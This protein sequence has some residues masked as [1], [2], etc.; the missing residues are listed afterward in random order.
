VFA[1][2][3][4]RFAIWAERPPEF[5]EEA[6]L[7]ADGTIVPRDAE[8]KRGMDFAYDGQ[9]SYHSLLISL[10]NTAEHLFCSIAV[11]IAR[12]R[13][14]PISSWTKPSSEVRRHDPVLPG[15]PD[16]RCD[17]SDDLARC[18]RQGLRIAV[19]R[20]ASGAL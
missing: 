12:R 16:L 2:S 10:A 19:A 3:C 17:G 1:P 8:C 9:Y 4:P 15:P 11:A 14:S 13:N 5:F 7:D 6:I 18:S 20:G